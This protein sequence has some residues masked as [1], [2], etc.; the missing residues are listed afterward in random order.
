MSPQVHLGIDKKH[1][2]MA[3]PTF[4]RLPYTLRGVSCPISDVHVACLF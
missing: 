2:E 3:G 1:F 4:F